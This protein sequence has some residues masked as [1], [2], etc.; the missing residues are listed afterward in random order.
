MNRSVS[1]VMMGVASLAVLGMTATLAGAQTLIDAVKEKP[2]LYRYES[3]WVFPPAHW[4]DVAKDNATANQKVLAPALADGTLVGYGD[5]ENM[6]N[7]GEGFT[8]GNWWLANSSP[9]VLKVLDAFDKGS[10]SSSSR[11]INSTQHWSQLYISNYY[12]WKA[13]SWKGAYELRFAYKLRPSADPQSATLMLS[14]FYVPLFEK[15]LADGAIVEYDID[16]ESVHS[17]DSPGQIIFAFVAPN[18][19]GLNKFRPALIAAF[20]D[21]SLLTPV[22]ASLFVNE[23]VSASHWARVNATYK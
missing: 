10:A 6:V 16:R 21:N 22:K 2:A 1:R 7:P 4:G 5:D 11:L 23:E 3:Y 18:T 13:G 15:L 9:G 8:H 19:E 17:A 20:K 12:N 14:G